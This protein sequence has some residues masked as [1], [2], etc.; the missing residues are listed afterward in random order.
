VDH[1]A[2]LGID[3]GT[4]SA[5]ALVVDR[6]DGRLLGEASAA[7]PTHRPEPGAAEQSPDEWW[8]A[9]IYAVRRAISAAGNP[10]IDAIGL[11]GQMHGTVTLDAERR[12][13]APAIIWADQRSALDAIALTEELGSRLIE[14]AGSP[15]APGFQAATIHWMRRVQPER[16]ET[17]AFALLPK[18]YIRL[19]LTGDLVTDPSDASGTLLFDVNRREWS[20]ELMAAA[21]VDRSQLP[22]IAPSTARTGTLSRQA[23]LTLGLL[24]GIPVAGGAAD[25]PAAAL[26]AG[27]I[28]P[29]ELLLTLSSGAQAYTPVNVPAIHASGQLHTFATPFDGSHQVARFYTMG[30][31]LNAGLALTWLRDQVLG[32]TDDD[33]L[34]RISA[35]A[36]NGP[37]GSDGLIFLP[38]LSGERTPLFDTSARGAFLGL[39]AE[40]GPDAIARSVFEGISLALF[41]AWEVV[42]AETAAT[43]DQIVL[44]GAGARSLLWPQLIA[45]LFGLPVRVVSGGDQSAFGA[46]ILASSSIGADPVELADRWVR[47]ELEL[48]P[49]S[50]AHARYLELKPLF[51]DAYR[52]NKVIFERLA[53]WRN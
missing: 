12:A 3:L 52:A 53:R 2:I 20:P 17:T 41:D 16:W 40:H 26:G 50:V 22:D 47:Y 28:R 36:A 25:A 4:G 45:D 32:L 46:A 37:V 48:E 29:G 10:A 38:Y 19:Q 5:K 49:D 42:Q 13:S 24:P 31:T 14:I 11:S 6:D 18:D 30:A 43:P 39:S 15:I 51:R 33:A 23:G 44:A 27:V 34:E 1:R 9:T 7:Y 21:G 35:W 8:R